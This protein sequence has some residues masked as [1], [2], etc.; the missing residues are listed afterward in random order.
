LSTPGAVIASIAATA[1]KG[2]TW[3]SVRREPEVGVGSFS[4]NVGR[5]DA[6]TDAAHD[7]NNLLK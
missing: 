1:S 3:T 5:F 4:P 2:F 7:P 6:A